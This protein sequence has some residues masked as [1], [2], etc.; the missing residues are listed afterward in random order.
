MAVFG[1][2]SLQTASNN[3]IEYRRIANV[4]VD[5]SNLNSTVYA[6]VLYAERFISERNAEHIR[7]AERRID[8]SLTVIEHAISVARL[9]SIINAVTEAR[10]QLLAIRKYLGELE[11]NIGKMNRT[12]N[13]ECLPAMLATDKALKTMGENGRRDA[14]S[15]V[16][17]L[18]NLAWEDIAKAKELIVRYITTLDPETAR[19]LS[20]ILKDIESDTRNM[21]AMVTSPL[22]RSDHAA[23]LKAFSGVRPAFDKMIAS[24]SAAQANLAN[25]EANTRV[26]LNLIADTNQ[27][28]DDLLLANGTATLTSNDRAQF[29]LLAI[30]AVGLILGIGL[31]VVLINSLSR[32]LR[33][34]AKFAGDIAAGD[35]KSNVQ[36]T[37]KGEIGEMVTAVRHIPE[38]FSE[39]ITRCNAIADDIASGLFRNRLDTGKFQ[40]GFQE[41]AQGINTI[42]DSYTRSIDTL[43]VAIVTLDPQFNTRF[44]N[45][46]ALKI[47]GRD[48]RQAFGGKMPLMEKSLRDKATHQ[49]ESQL[50]GQEGAA[51]Q[52]AA[53]AMPL[54]DPAGKVVGG[55]EVLTDI[56]EIKNKQRIMLQVAGDASAIADR[57]ASAAEELAAHV[58]QVSRSAGMQRER[59]EGT[60]SAMTQMNSTV[61][62]VAKNASQAAEQSEHSRDN[63]QSGAKLV[64][65]V[66]DSINQ[67]H[68]VGARLEENMQALGL[69]AESI[70]SV[71]NVIS[72][73]ADQ[74]NLLALNAAIEAA[75]AGEAGRGFAVVADEV[76]KLAEKTMSAT[77]EVGDNIAAIQ[78]AARLNM[79]EVAVAV[80]EVN[81]ATG[82]ANESG[83]ALN[84]I[85]QLATSTSTVVSSI[86]TA[87][88]EQ[89]AASEQITAS[90]DEI[91]RLV[92]ETAAG[93]IQSSAAVQDLSRTAQE[94]RK[95][96]ED[97]R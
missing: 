41:L 88:E 60:A 13:E 80:E 5:A 70:G 27:V 95:V 81:T 59:V 51:M 87:A 11:A 57:V 36:I 68:K 9:D 16:L 14:N 84:D 6:A 17:Y 7:E 8:K 18:Q 69:K 74:T 89:S 90:V 20:D 67:V 78:E 50:T 65:R 37:E 79:Q 46:A 56:T 92:G 64:G 52:V 4:N 66:I 28:S 72:D 43:P 82:L 35:F 29:N 76:R 48:V 2:S 25:V 32:T 55:L 97:L 42:A 61:A 96:M 71:M 49:A 31:A 3:F 53:T 83:T 62:E 47:L 1:Y 24:G 75:R 33:R 12:F 21:S 10:T 63:A 73:I 38:I 15:E 93:M 77:K 86:A 44:T 30:S 91:N 45:N 22:G 19:E 94:L 34:M 23:M 54:L 85:L 58:E 40:G 26:I 39:V